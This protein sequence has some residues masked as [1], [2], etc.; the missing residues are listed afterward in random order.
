MKV[1]VLMFSKDQNNILGQFKNSPLGNPKATA[2]EPRHDDNVDYT[3]PKA[4]CKNM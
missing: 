4:N 1:S 3:T 2:Q